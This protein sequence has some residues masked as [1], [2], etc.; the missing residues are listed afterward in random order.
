M[1]SFRLLIICSY[2]LNTG[3]HVL[4]KIMR[5]EF[6]RIADLSKAEQHH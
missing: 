4:L 2:Q 5:E 3:T 6:D 1:A